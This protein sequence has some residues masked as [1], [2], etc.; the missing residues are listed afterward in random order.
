MKSC[1]A[2]GFRDI[3]SRIPPDSRIIFSS[4]VE[5]CS[6]AVDVQSPVHASDLQYRKSRISLSSSLARQNLFSCDLAKI[7]TFDQ[8]SK[9]NWDI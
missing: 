5:I 7:V 1:L 8:I 3:C 4:I 2:T 9:H 6:A